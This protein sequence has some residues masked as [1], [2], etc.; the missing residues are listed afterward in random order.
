[1]HSEGC[2]N[3]ES[4][5]Q[6]AHKNSGPDGSKA[7]LKL[8]GK[9]SMRKIFVALLVGLLFIGIGAAGTGGNNGGNNGGNGGHDDHPQMPVKPSEA[10]SC[11]VALAG[12]SAFVDK[13]LIT[14][15]EDELVV[16]SNVKSN[17]FQIDDAKVDPISASLSTGSANAG[18]WGDIKVADDK[19]GPNGNGRGHN[20]GGHDNDDCEDCVAKVA[21]VAG[22]ESTAFNAAMGSEK[23]TGSTFTLNTADVCAGPW[24]LSSVSGATSISVGEACGIPTGEDETSLVD[25][26]EDIQEVGCEGCDLTPEPE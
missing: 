19:Q 14:S 18:I 22:S 1:M 26:A 5:G 13:C 20:D 25:L 8:R 17:T 3:C 9:N 15:Q 7:I 21:I 23:A 16:Y 4:D 12:A 24:G 6:I 2:I 10:K 11:A